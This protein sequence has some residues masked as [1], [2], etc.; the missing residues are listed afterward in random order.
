[1]H[2]H[3]CRTCSSRGKDPRDPAYSCDGCT[4]SD[5]YDDYCDREDDR[6]KDAAVFEAE[7]REREGA[8]DA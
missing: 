4:K 5:D 7:E 3:P 8:G 1:M 2:K 6:R